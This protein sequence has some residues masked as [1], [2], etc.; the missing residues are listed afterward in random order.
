MNSFR[1]AEMLLPFGC[2]KSHF[3]L[4]V[5]VIVLGLESWLS[6]IINQTIYLSHRIIFTSELLVLTY[7]CDS[8]M[9]L[10]IFDQWYKKEVEDVLQINTFKQL[11]Q[12]Q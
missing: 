5:F 3:E 9:Q 10:F 1:V 6:L 12:S 11:F 8:V 2:S 7:R 4:S